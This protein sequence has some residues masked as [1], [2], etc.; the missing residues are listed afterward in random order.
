MNELENIPLP[1]QPNVISANMLVK[2]SGIIGSDYMQFRSSKL[3]EGACIITRHID[4][5][6]FLDFSAA[7]IFNKLMAIRFFFG[8][9]KIIKI[10]CLKMELDPLWYRPELKS[11][12]PT[13]QGIQYVEI[14]EGCHNFLSS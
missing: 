6:N 10:N 4:L 7:L 14:F 1:W 8:K 9:Q 5:T 2:D 3:D 13:I 11:I 12:I